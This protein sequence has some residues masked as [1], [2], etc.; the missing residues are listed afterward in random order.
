MLHP[1]IFPRTGSMILLYGPC[2][3]SNGI[4]RVTLDRYEFTSNTS[5]P[6]QSDDC[7]LFQSPGLSPSFYHEL[8][9]ENVDGRAFSL[10]RVEILRGGSLVSPGSGNTISEI[11]GI[12]LFVVLLA[13]GVVTVYTAMTKKSTK[14]FTAETF[15]ESLEPF[16][17]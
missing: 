11:V 1:F 4:M 9:I 7:L 13:V 14:R 8:E 15:D 3:P 10:N 6:L 2:G 17:R 16:L 5:K 12:M